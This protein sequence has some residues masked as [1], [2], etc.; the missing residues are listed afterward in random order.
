[1]SGS[2]PNVEHLLEY[3][4]YLLAYRLRAMVGG[5]LRPAARELRM[6]EYA[7]LRLERQRLAKALLDS[8][9]Y[10]DGLRRVEALTD[11]L[12]FGF[13][14]NPGET[15]V[16]L[17]KIVQAGGCR[18][19]ESEDGF[20]DALLT[21]AERRRVGE[22]G[23]RTLARYYLGLVRASAAYLDPD[24]FTRLRDDIEPLRSS[25]PMFLAAGEDPAPA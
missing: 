21:R 4:D 22:E 7:R 9:D 1:M 17:K 16:V 23:A 12:N 2:L 10:R 3:Q 6:S 5:P 20:A 11:Q 19:L 15:V 25:L 14:H 18:A 24:V 8:D 13:W